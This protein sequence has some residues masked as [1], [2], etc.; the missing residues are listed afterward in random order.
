[1]P[2]LSL[3]TGV[4]FFYTDSGAVDGGEYTTVVIIH[5]YSFHSGT[6]QR[7][8]P[9]AQPN[10]LRII[11]VNRRCYPGSS[12]LSADELSTIAEGTDDARAGLLEQQGCDLAL[13]VDGLIDELSIPKNGGIALVGWS[14]GTI[15][16]LSLIASVET[17]P[18]ATQE[19]L[20]GYVR[21]VVLLQPPSLSLGLPMP[22]GHL[23]SH[24]DP[25]IAEARGPAFA[26]WVSSYFVHGNL[27]L[28]KTEEL[29]N[30]K[31]DP[32]KLSTVERLKPEELFALADFTAAEKYDKVIGGAPFAP[33]VAAQTHKVLFDPTVRR[34]WR[35]ATFWNLYGSA[36][37]WTIIYAGW[38]LED[39]SRAAN[40]LALAFQTKIIPG[41]NHF[42][43][44]DEPETT[45]M[46]LKA[47]FSV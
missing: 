26:K 19:R 28:H 3:S 42:L 13:F 47:C 8:N 36:E 35:G 29:T 6:F 2:S 44:W 22:P 43:A 46:A 21:T 23:T 1:M 7:L 17:L 41:G 30:N 9:L 18:T 33:L 32:L 24:T 12:A 11:S 27:S 15:F 25:D 39:Q 40:S 16:L 37:P 14:L 20:S 10:S 31:T 5:G 4:Q 45:I 34:A 38:F